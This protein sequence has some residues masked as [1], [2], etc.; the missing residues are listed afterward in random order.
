M[1]MD[2][3]GLEKPQVKL[4]GMELNMNK[5]GGEDALIENLELQ[6]GTET[7]NPNA[8]CIVGGYKM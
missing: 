3:S 4:S 2:E 7:D 1:F 6:D 5:F 8:A